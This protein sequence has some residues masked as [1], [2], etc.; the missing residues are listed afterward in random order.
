MIAQHLQYKLIVLLRYLKYFLSNKTTVGT[1]NFTQKTSRALFF[2]C[3]SSFFA[4]WLTFLFFIAASQQAQSDNPP[5]YA[6]P[7]GP[8]YQAPPPAYTPSP[9]GYYGWVPPTHVFPDQPPGKLPNISL[10]LF[11]PLLLLFPLQAHLQAGPLPNLVSLPKKNW[12]LSGSSTKTEIYS[13]PGMK[14]IQESQSFL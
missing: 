10:F 4:S 2:A 3:V 9:T 5:P 14:L 13:S 6:P 8:W 12:I 11:P 1:L 7:P